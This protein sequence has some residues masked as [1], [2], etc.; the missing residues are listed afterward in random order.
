MLKQLLM[1]LLLC[2]GTLVAH[3]QRAKPTIE[4]DVALGLGKDIVTGALSGTRWHALGTKGKLQ[5]GYGIRLTG[6]F[7]GAQEYITA[8][9]ELSRQNDGFL[10]TL[11][12]DVKNENLDTLLVPGATVFALNLAGHLRYRITERWAVGFNI[13]VVGVSFG[14][15]DPSRFVSSLRGS[16]ASTEQA[17][18]TAFNLLLIGDN[19]RGSLNS[20]L[21]VAYQLNAHW[22]LRAGISHLFVEATTKRPLTFDNDRF[23]RVSD[24]G[25]FAVSYK[26]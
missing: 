23:R 24:L 8:P 21:Y 16:S 14:S 6:A 22:G 25:F 1:V 5:L 26:F 19:D 4:A 12:S 13:D 10:V 9:A 18:P 2:G 15:V 20:E 17:S 3:A 11:F 7:G